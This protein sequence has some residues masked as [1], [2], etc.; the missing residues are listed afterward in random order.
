MEKKPEYKPEVVFVE[1]DGKRYDACIVGYKDDGTLPPKADGEM[2]LLAKDVGLEGKIKTLGV[3]FDGDMPVPL[4]G[5]SLCAIKEFRGVET[6]TGR[7]NET[8]NEKG[9]KVRTEIVRTRATVDLMVNFG[10]NKRGA[11]WQYMPGIS[12]KDHILGAHLMAGQSGG[13][14]YWDY[15][16]EAKKEPEAKEK[17]AKK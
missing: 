5:T 8:T 11:V 6:R 4:I 1:S 7:I 17:H 16:P 3:K 10:S 14:R 13:K 2:R 15:L 9:E 12:Y